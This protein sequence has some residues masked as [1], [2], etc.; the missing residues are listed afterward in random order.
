MDSKEVNSEYEVAWI[1][2]SDKAALSHLR[3]TNP[4]AIGVVR[5]GDRY[6]LRVKSAQAAALHK[7]IL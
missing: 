6:G 4:A 1:P 7:T 5:I 2:K 3:Q